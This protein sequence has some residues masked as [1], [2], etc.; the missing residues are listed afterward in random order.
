M[1]R[2]L[3]CTRLCT[4]MCVYVCLCCM[5]GRVLWKRVGVGH[6]QH[7][8]SC[9]KRVLRFVSRI[10][11]PGR[12]QAQG[13]GGTS[14]QGRLLTALLPVPGHLSQQAVARIR[15]TNQ[16][17]HV[18]E[19]TPEHVVVCRKRTR[20]WAPGDPTPPL[21]SSGTSGKLPLHHGVHFPI[22]TMMRLD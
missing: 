8:S 1:K 20:A 2:A 21:L 16:V 14:Q 19:P 7:R 10:L 15:E 17:G 22:C 4:Y 18:H 9:S 13:I 3:A 5:L 6:I 11:C 12:L